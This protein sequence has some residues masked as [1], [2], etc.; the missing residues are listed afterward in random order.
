M[1]APPSSAPTGPVPETY[2]VLSIRTA[3][4]NPMIGSYGDVPAM[5]CRKQSAHAMG[6]PRSRFQ[7][8][9]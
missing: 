3:R 1:A 5:F 4:E 6:A 7:D 2:T 9:G 8:L